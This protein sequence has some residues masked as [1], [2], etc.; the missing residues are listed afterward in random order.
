MRTKQSLPG[1]I[2]QFK[3]SMVYPAV[4]VLALVIVAPLLYS[5]YISFHKYVLQ[6]GMGKF[7]FLENYLSAFIN[8]DFLKSMKNMKMKIPI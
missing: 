8:I 1:K 2:F 6:F 3:Y 7:T 4:I 5:L